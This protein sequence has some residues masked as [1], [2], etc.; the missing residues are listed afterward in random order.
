MNFS[1][2]PELN[3]HIFFTSPHKH[4]YLF[5]YDF[6]QRFF[7]VWYRQVLTYVLG[8][9]DGLIG[10]NIHVSPVTKSGNND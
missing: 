3:I 1:L 7:L 9:C 2:K 8:A 5:K 10:L 6:G 4:I